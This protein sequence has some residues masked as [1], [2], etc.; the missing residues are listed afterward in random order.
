MFDLQIK[1]QWL[2]KISIVDDNFYVYPNFDFWP[3]CRFLT[4]MS[5]FVENFNFYQNC[6]FDE[7]LVQNRNFRQK[8]NNLQQF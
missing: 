3:K 6:D 4:K 2:G 5:I 8:S 7:I 1:F